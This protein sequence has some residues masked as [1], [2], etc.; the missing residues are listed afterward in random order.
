MCRRVE[1]RQCGGPTFA[2]CGQHVEQ[3]LG[4]IAPA[5]RCQCRELAKA[6]GQ[7]SNSKRTP[8]AWLKERFAK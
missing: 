4:D 6:R 5:E 8:L 1:C 2:G 3:V 7:G